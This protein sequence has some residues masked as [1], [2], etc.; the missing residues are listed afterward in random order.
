MHIHLNRDEARLILLTPKS[1]EFALFAVHS[2]CASFCFLGQ[3]HFTHSKHPLK[4]THTHIYTHPL[5][6]TSPHG[7]LSSEFGSPAPLLC[8]GPQHRH[9]RRHTIRRRHRRAAQPSGGRT[10]ARPPFQ[11]SQTN[12]KYCQITST[13]KTHVRKIQK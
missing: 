13:Q 10:P 8:V 11:T 6:Y 4:Y 3:R 12:T 5:K 7:S 9:H 2:N 1:N